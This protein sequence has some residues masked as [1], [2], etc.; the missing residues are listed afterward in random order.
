MNRPTKAQIRAS[1]EKLKA[2]SE[3]SEPEKPKTPALE[4]K[5]SNKNRIR[6][7]GI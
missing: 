2:P 3:S 5:K 7:Q 6:K 1:V 4:G